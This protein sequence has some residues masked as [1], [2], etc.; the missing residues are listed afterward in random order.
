MP[1]LP[2]SQLRLSRYCDD[3][4]LRRDAGEVF[5]GVLDVLRPYDTSGKS[6][7]SVQRVF[8]RVYRTTHEHFAVLYPLRALV[9]ACK[10]LT[11]INLRSCA[12]DQSSPDEF[13]VSPRSLDGV[14][15]SFRCPKPDD[16]GLPVTDW[17]A[18]FG[19]RTKALLRKTSPLSLPVVLERVEEEPVS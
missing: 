12:L 18:A 16:G 9:T 8:V 3:T 2:S 11:S 5:S 10:P 15:L 7:P 13:R 17:M 19:A 1:C 6:A 4:H 14:S